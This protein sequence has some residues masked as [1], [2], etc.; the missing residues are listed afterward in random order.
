MIVKIGNSAGNLT[1]RPVQ[2]QD[3]PR[4][5]EIIS[6]PRVTSWFTWRA[7]SRERME[8]MIQYDIATDPADRW[9]SWTETVGNQVVGVVSVN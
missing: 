8:E 7:W 1:L 4:L 5:V 3:I 2:R 6:D 9:N